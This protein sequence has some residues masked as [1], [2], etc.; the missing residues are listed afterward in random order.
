MYE[1]DSPP[2]CNSQ[3]ARCGHRTYAEPG[4]AITCKKMNT[5]H[6]HTPIENNTPDTD[7]QTHTTRTTLQTPKRIP[8]KHTNYYWVD[9]LNIYVYIFRP[10]AAPR[11]RAA[12]IAHM[13]SRGARSPAK[14]TRQ[15]W[16]D[17]VHV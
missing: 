3:N 2:R 16:V 6:T 1:S 10:A 14:H 15:Y 4:L 9:V 13:Q 7:A 8:P 17:V 5:S 11:K 12:A